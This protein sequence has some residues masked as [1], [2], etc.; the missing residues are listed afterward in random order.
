MKPIVGATQSPSVLR[1]AAAEGQALEASMPPAMDSLLQRGQGQS[2]RAKGGQALAGVSSSDCAV[3][4]FVQ[5][6]STADTYPELH[7]PML[8]KFHT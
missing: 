6:R 3:G 2:F 5:E 7:K 1:A 4:I 8:L